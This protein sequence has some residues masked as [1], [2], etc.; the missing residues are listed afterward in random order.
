MTDLRATSVAACLLGVGDELS[1]L[2]ECFHWQCLG[3]NVSRLLQCA[4]P[5]RLNDSCV[6]LLADE[7]MLDINVLAARGYALCL[8]D[9]DGG[10]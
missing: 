3:E 4:D 8:A 9:G 7:M 2:N 1:M 10:L 5:L 6:N